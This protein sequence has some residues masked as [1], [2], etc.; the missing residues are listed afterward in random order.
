MSIFSAMEERDHEQLVFCYDKESGLRA[1]IAIHDTTL[2]PALGG[3]RLWHYESEA[4]AVRDALRLSR[5]MTYKAAAAG[6]NLGGGKTV[7]MADPQRAKSEV[8]FRSLGRFI[9]RLNGRYITAE[10][11]GTTVADM[12]WV[13]METS[14]V[15]GLSLAEGGLG[16]PSP[17]TALG[18]YHGLRAALNH[19]FGH[20]HLE[21]HTVAVQGLGQVGNHLVGHLTS[22]GAHVVACDTDPLKIKKAQERYPHLKI[23]A[24]AEI[25]DV[26]CDVFAPCALG[27]VVNSK[28]INRL[29]CAIIAGSANNVLEN[30]ESDS[31]LLKDK[32]IL[33][34]P[35]FVIS[36]G[37]LINVSNELAHRQTKDAL[38][39][40]SRIFD[41]VAHV[42]STA[43]KENI[44][45]QAAALALAER[46]IASIGALKRR[47]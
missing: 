35:D 25:Y 37:G 13:R 30:E 34:V 47:S 11:V 1:I 2:G 16:D 5:G 41:I 33:Y 23:I 32:K 17:V 15:T 6:L 26:A 39:Q 12:A 9:E 42:L 14:Y 18:V 21:G 20:E 46:R 10:D 36:A 40:T 3:C 8:L 4:D 24:P 22:A 38:A 31:L 43:E 28:T 27:A 44:T 29:R 19:Y 45:T 7:I